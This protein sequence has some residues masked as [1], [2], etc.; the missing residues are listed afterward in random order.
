MKVAIRDSLNLLGAFF[1]KPESLSIK[2]IPFSLDNKMM[3][4]E[5]HLNL[6]I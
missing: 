2:N 4:M 3:D 1:H 5:D 6:L